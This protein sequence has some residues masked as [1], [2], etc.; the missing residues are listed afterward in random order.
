MF[1]HHLQLSSET[2]DFE[3]GFPL[4]CDVTA[5]GRVKAGVQPGGEMLS[6]TFTGPYEGLYAAWKAFG[7]ATA[8]NDSEFAS[9]FEKSKT[10]LEIYSKGP[11]SG[12]DASTY[13]TKLCLPLLK[14]E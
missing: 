5:A 1:A 4:D 12:P 6:A 2:F 14:K 8:T 10:V 3:V 11:E 9:K 7:D 13:E